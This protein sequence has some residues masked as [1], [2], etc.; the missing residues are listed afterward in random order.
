MDAWGWS[1]SVKSYCCSR[2]W[3]LHTTGKNKPNKEDKMFF[4]ENSREYLLA[5]FSD[6]RSHSR[7]L[8]FPPSPLDRERGKRRDLGRL[9]IRLSIYLLESILNSPPISSCWQPFWGLS[10]MVPHLKVINTVIL[11]L[12]YLCTTESPRHFLASTH[13]PKR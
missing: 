11:S 1:K 9:R 7:S 10:I 6:V 2:L 13:T 3:K 12:G 5:W 4:I 8:C